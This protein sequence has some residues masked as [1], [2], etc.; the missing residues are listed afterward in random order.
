MPVTFDNIGSTASTGA[1][2]S[3]LFTAAANTVMLMF[4]RQSVS[5]CAY[6]GVALTRLHVTDRNEIW[7]LTAPATGA[8]TLAVTFVNVATNTGCIVATYNNAK[9]V[10]PFGTP[11]GTLTTGTVGNLSLSSTTTDLVVMGVWLNDAGGNIIFNAGMTVR[12][13]RSCVAQYKL[14]LADRAGA[15]TLSLSASNGFSTG[16]IIEGIPVK[17]SAAA[18]TKPF[19][20]AMLGAGS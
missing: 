11:Q 19:N 18:A 16:F 3:I 17:F 5:V 15:A 10:G 20:L 1:T 13:T 8:N 4:T 12:Q 9:A 6:N 2:C 7:G 14:G